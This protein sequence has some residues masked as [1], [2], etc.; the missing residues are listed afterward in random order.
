MPRV[1]EP[2]GHHQ[3]IVALARILELAIWHTLSVY[4]EVALLDFGHS[5]STTAHVLSALRHV[6]QIVLINC[7]DI[8]STILVIY[9]F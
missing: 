1:G 9:V 4:P 5:D 3:V 8:P 2:L 7:V 6:C